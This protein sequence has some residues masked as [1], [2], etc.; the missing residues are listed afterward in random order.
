MDKKLRVRAEE[1][2]DE[3][4]AKRKRFDFHRDLRLKEVYPDLKVEGKAKVSGE[5]VYVLRSSPSPNGT[6]RFAFSTQTGLLVWQ[7]SEY[8]TI[9]IGFNWGARPR[10]RTRMQFIDYHNV[11]GI[12]V[13]ACW[14]SIAGPAN[15]GPTFELTFK[16]TEIKHNVPVDDALFEKPTK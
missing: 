3:D 6:E 1:E 9:P 8:E 12:K 7:E 2:S 4:L 15:G 10:V 5:E 14:H 13:P 16:A 11:G